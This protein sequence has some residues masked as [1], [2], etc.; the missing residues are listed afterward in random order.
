MRTSGARCLEVAAAPIPE[1][2]TQHSRGRRARPAPG[3]AQEGRDHQA[4]KAEEAAA[5]RGGAEGLGGAGTSHATPGPGTWEFSK[6]PESQPCLTSARHTHGLSL[7]S[8][9]LSPPRRPCRA[10]AP[11][12][13]PLVS[14]SACLGGS[15]VFPNHVSDQRTSH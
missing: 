4:E 15:A 10:E 3:R 2:A 6:L 11:G 7:V 12:P 14:S 5:S 9:T 13:G 1:A 8:R